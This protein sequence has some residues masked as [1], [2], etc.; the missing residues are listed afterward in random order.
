MPLEPGEMYAVWRP[1][2]VV[3]KRAVAGIRNENEKEAPLED[4]VVVVPPTGVLVVGVRPLGAD[5]APPP[6][7]PVAASIP[8]IAASDRIRDFIGSFQKEGRSFVLLAERRRPERAG[9]IRHHPDHVVIRR[10]LEKRRD[11]F[12]VFVDSH[13]KHTWTSLHCQASNTLTRQAKPR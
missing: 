11:I 4:V 2:E 9:F 3:P 5:P 7:Q 12:S 10:N 8:A 6:L 13:S 1:V